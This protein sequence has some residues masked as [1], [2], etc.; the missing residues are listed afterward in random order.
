MVGK[1]QWEFYGA[2]SDLTISYLRAIRSGQTLRFE[3]EVQK[4][5][6]NI[7][8]QYTKVFDD[9][10]GDLCVTATFTKARA[11]YKLGTNHRSNL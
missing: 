11:D 2:A 5:T 8:H 9:D 3:C 10:N 6:K 4:V 7:S 1:H